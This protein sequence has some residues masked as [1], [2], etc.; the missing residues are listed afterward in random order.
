MRLLRLTDFRAETIK[1]VSK[2][3]TMRQLLL[4]LLFAACNRPTPPPKVIRPAFYTWKTTFHPGSW[5]T[6]TL[7][8]WN[9]QRLYIKYADIDWRE[10]K[11]AIPVSTTA[12][13]W[14]SLPVDIAP[15]PVFFIVNRVFSNITA[16][17]SITLVQRI[18]QR[19][20]ET[21]PK[22]RTI[23]EIQIDCDWNSTT[24]AAYFR[25]LEQLK[26][27][28]DTSKTLQQPQL[29]ATIRLH[30]IK[31]REKTGVPP[32][33]RGLLMLYNFDSPTKT[34]VKN[35][36]IDPAT[37]A[38]Y[39]SQDTKPYPIPLDAAL[40]LFGWGLHFRGNDFQGFLHDLRASTAAQSRFLTRV[41]Q[42]IFRVN[43]DTSC[44]D[45]Y[46]RRGDWIRIEEA[47]P[48]DLSRVWEMAKPLIANDTCHLVFFDLNIQNLQYYRHED[49]I[50]IR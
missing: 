50:K 27:Q 25:F 23:P 46:F 45:T 11:G 9:A 49:L 36:I 26:A 19:V 29:S 39:L 28:T 14:D 47:A 7:H 15:V 18:L 6:Q 34:T 32:V 41:E 35:S 44:W 31:Y 3:N 16:T 38:Q 1:T 5:E 33:D 24:K 2:S 37:A 40:P 13:Q 42:N 10:G 43:A 8:Q 30:Q 12:M 4:L 21:T 17:E 20:R 48:D 22:E